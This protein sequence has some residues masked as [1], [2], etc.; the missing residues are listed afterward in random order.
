M[1]N[2]PTLLFYVSVCLT[3]L[4]FCSIIFIALLFNKIETDK[5][6]FNVLSKQ[7]EKTAICDVETVKEL[8][9]QRFKEDYYITQESNNTNL[10]LSV[11]AITVV[12]F[13][14]SSFTLFES[15]VNEHKKYYSD[16]IEEQD[17]KHSIFNVHFENLLMDVARKEGYDNSHKALT[18]FKDMEYDWFIYYTLESIKHFSDYYVLAK[19]KEG[20]EN[21][22]NSVITNQI[23]ILNDALKK[24]EN[25]E[26]L[27]DFEPELT[28]SYIK[29][30]Q[31]FNSVEITKLVSKL[32]SKLS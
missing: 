31:R 23:D 10:I 4:L 13:S 1:K 32:Y 2:K 17:R 9:Q 22:S 8:S 12:L 18:H 7:I 5:N 15:R 11:F 26:K 16:K 25:V 30:I 21:L 6:R 19:K 24:T 27:K 3:L 28:Q 20:S 29:D 14:F